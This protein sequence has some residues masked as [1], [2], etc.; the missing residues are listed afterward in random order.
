M[1]RAVSGNIQ[2]NI[3]LLQLECIGGLTRRFITG[4]LAYG[5]FLDIPAKAGQT[6]NIRIEHGEITEIKFF[7]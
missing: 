1:V 5:V 2:G 7:K 3:T 6:V 4:A